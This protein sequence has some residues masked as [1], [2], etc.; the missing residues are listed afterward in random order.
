MMSVDGYY[1]CPVCDSEFFP[2]EYFRRLDP[3]YME[4]WEWSM[5]QYWKAMRNEFETARV[6][7][8]IARLAGLL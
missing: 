5:R 4:L 8:K 3:E 7:R 6:D 2:P 1:Q